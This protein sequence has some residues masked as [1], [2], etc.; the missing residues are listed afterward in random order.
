MASRAPAY[1]ATPLDVL[2][3]SVPSLPRPIL[4]RLTARMIERLDE[5]DDEAVINREEEYR[6]SAPPPR[7]RLRFGR[8][9]EAHAVAIKMGR[10]LY[11]RRLQ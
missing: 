2:L 9:D 11:P 6:S 4:A 5:L 7:R 3:A 8:A 10:D 1:D